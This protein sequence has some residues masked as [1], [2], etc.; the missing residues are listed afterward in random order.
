MLADSKNARQRQYSRQKLGTC[1]AVMIDTVV[2]DDYVPAN[3]LCCCC[4]LDATARSVLQDKETKNY[5]E[6]SEIFVCSGGERKIERQ[7]HYVIIN[8]WQYLVRLIH[9]QMI[10]V[11]SLSLRCDESNRDY[12]ALLSH[13]KKPCAQCI[14]YWQQQG[15]GSVR[16]ERAAA[17]TSRSHPSTC[18][19][20]FA[21]LTWLDL[22]ILMDSTK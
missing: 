7:L 13:L 18:C 11:R 10:L 3:W 12:N 20:P 17:W 4:M 16:S 22:K 1:K 15:G 5:D 6:S 2:V 21:S 8:N 14:F 9:F 19:F